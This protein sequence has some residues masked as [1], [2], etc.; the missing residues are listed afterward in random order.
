MIQYRYLIAFSINERTGT[1]EMGFGAPICT[2][3]DVA[4]IQAKLRAHL[5]SPDVMVLAFSRFADVDG[6]AR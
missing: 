5:G 3:A 1:I 2:T 4:G 6:G